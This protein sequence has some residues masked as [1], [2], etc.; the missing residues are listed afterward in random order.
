[1]GWG[2]EYKNTENFGFPLFFL[3]KVRRIG[4]F[5]E[6]FVTSDYHQGRTPANPPLSARHAGGF[7]PSRHQS[8]PPGPDSSEPPSS[9]RHAGNEGP[10]H[11]NQTEYAKILWV[12]N[13]VRKVSCRA[14][15]SPK[16]CR[17]KGR[18]LR[19]IP[20]TMEEWPTST[21]RL[22]TSNG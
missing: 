2:N 18:L 1:M 22:I 5:L 7:G 6:L 15:G 3:P 4:R 14:E 12:S 17:S 11:N 16:E 10:R 20:T 9:A 19:I 8:H 13:D 21:Q